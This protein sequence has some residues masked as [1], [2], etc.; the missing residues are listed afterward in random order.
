MSILK[1]LQV[2]ENIFRYVSDDDKALV[3]SFL[4]SEKENLNLNSI[5]HVH[6]LSRSEHLMQDDIQEEEDLLIY[7]L[8]ESEYNPLEQMH[9]EYV[10]VYL[11]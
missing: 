1:E 4:I 9:Q 5:D 6:L 8:K 2:N 11:K 7:S 3:V 10:Y